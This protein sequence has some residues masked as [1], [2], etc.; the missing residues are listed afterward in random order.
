MVIQFLTSNYL[1]FKEQATLTLVASSLKE[2][3]IDSEDIIFP[4]EGTDINLMSSAA[5]LGANASGKSNLIKAINFFKQFIINSFKERQAGED[6]PVDSFRLNLET[7]KEPS[8]FEISI[9]IDGYIF[10]YGFE[11]TR[12]RVE[13][14]WLYKKACKKRAKEVELYYRT[15]KET[16]VHPK[17]S[18]AQELVNKNMV[19]DNAL[20]LS[21]LA[22][23]NDPTAVS[24]IGWLNETDVIFCSDEDAAW[25]NAV[26]HL[27][28][29]NM[30]QRIVEFSK[31]ADLGINNIEKVNDHL[32]SSHVAYDEEGR[33]EGNVSFSFEDNES[34]GTLKYFSLAYPILNA[35]DHG[36]RIIIDEFD[37]K[38]HPLLTQ[39]IIS[40]FNSKETNPH[41]AQLIFTT[42]DTNLL[43]AGLFRRDQVWFTEKDR[44]GATSL[45]SLSDYKVRSNS[46]FERDYLSGKYGAIPV[47]GNIN[48]VMNNSYGK[49]D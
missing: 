29:N 7:S 39:H 46:P 36:H 3:G 38:L 48:H 37:S 4:V 40:L 19:R 33:P 25:K 18:Q 44:F 24:F 21:T 28:D 20:L 14:E 42:H 31:Y 12:N 27:D 10:R 30:R 22:Q 32:I 6:I 17:Y 8:S 45:Y 49:E 5:I 47:I 2:T 9:V 13:A 23:F 26:R 16:T 11:V 34:E 35:L 1:S 43:S 41:H 15:A